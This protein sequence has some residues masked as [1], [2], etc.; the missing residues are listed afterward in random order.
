MLFFE[1]MSYVFIFSLHLPLKT[2]ELEFYSVRCILN[3]EKD[4]GEELEQFYE[5]TYKCTTT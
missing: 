4:T 2:A 5:F 3:G 1:G